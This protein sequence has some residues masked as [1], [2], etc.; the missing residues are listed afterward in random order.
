[1][2]GRGQFRVAADDDQG[3]QFLSRMVSTAGPRKNEVYLWPA[4]IGFS[5]R[6]QTATAWAGLP[7]GPLAA[8]WTN[9]SEER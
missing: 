5:A 6:R 4:G 7:R 9:P 1:M 8:R 3:R 2:A